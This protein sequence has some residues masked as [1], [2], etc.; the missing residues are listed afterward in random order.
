M[1]ERFNHIETYD[2]KHQNF[3]PDEQVKME[4]EAESEFRLLREMSVDN[5]Q[6]MPDGKTRHWMLAQS[7]I[8]MQEGAAET[9]D[10]ESKV[11]AAM[12]PDNAVKFQEPS[13]L[14]KATALNAYDS[15]Q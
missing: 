3:V 4:K 9:L 13:D 11:R 6:I 5:D 7:H 12:D 2:W 1:E 10:R 8:I 15:I 14:D